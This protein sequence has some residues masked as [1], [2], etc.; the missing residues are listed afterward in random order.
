MPIEKPLPL[1]V[2]NKAYYSLTSYGPVEIE[3]DVPYTSEEDIQI[4]L[5]MTIADL[6]GTMADL[7]NP[8][9]VAEHFDGLTT[10]QQVEAAM[11]Q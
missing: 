10:R 4:G 6:G 9:W 5:E 7:D 2:G 11:R 1:M 8:E 3:V